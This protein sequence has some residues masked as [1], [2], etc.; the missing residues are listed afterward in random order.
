MKKVFSILLVAFAMSAI[1]AS[2]EKENVGNGNHT[3]SVPTDTIPVDTIPTDTVDLGISA[4]ELAD[5]T[6][7]TLTV[8]AYVT[9]SVDQYLGQFPGYTCGIVWSAEGTPTMNS[10]VVTCTADAQGRFEATIEGL[11][12]GT[13]YKMAAWLKLTPEGE[14]VVS[15]VR[16]YSAANTLPGPNPQPVE[17]D[18]VDLGL[19]S[20]LLWATCN[21]G[22]TAPE[23]YGNKFAWGETQP[24]SV[25]NW[26]TYVYG[27]DF[28]HLTKYCNN[29]S[30]GL[31]GF[32]D[33]LT[34][35]EPSDDAA[36]INLGGGARTPTKAEWEE[37]MNNTTAELTTLNGV[38]GRRFTAPNGNSLFLP[39]AGRRSGTELNNAGIAGYYWSASLWTDIPDQASYF[40][41]YPEGQGMYIW[42]RCDGLSVRAVKNAN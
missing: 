25:Y 3:D 23:K 29:S 41:S 37:L 9:G 36:T 27:N 35:L 2:C 14:A 40:N 16:A 42:S 1:V 12:A 24:K 30:Y 22:A 7:S 34:T 11:S 8:T 21:V 6:E 20:G 19:P 15:D 32:T 5:S 31:N 28:E 26:S 18:W 4:P 38:N 10:N 33:N 39:S 17:V 13:E